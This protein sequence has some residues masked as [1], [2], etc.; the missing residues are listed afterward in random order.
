M[1]LWRKIRWSLTVGRLLICLELEIEP[2]IVGRRDAGC[3][4]KHCRS[5]RCGRGPPALAGGL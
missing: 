3:G 1:R 4:S 5:M 2:I